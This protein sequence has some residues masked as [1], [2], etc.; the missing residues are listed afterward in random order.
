[1]PNVAGGVPYETAIFDMDGTLVD[2]LCMT[3]GAIAAHAP[4]C[5]LRVLSRE[6]ILPAIGFGNEEFYRALYPEADERQRRRIE[7]LVEAGE[8]AIGRT[9]GEKILF[10]GV[11]P[12]LRCLQ[13][14][15]IRLVIASTATRAHVEGCLGIGG[16]LPF[17]REI[18]CGELDKTDMVRRLCRGRSAV[19]GDS[20]KDVVAAHQNG[21]AALGAGFGYAREGG[22]AFDAI[23]DTPKTLLC[24]L[25]GKSQPIA[26]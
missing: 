17:F 1:M 26:L 11:V 21:L 4:Q 10:D 24:A 16:I 20:V 9:L 13:D 15:G 25:T 3:V 12:M 14:A 5:G 23:F 18:A 2:T 6:E 19:V 8:L 22:A 7:A